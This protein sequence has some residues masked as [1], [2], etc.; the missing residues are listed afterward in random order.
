MLPISLSVGKSILWMLRRLGRTGSALPG[1]VVEKLYKPFLPRTLAQ[2]P[3]GVIVVTG[4]NGK[5]TTAKLIVELFEAQGL[6]VLTNK[7]G[8]NF[9]RGIITTVVDKATL[10]GKLDYDIAVLEQ[11]EA[12]AV[13]FVAQVKPVGVVALNVMRD[14]MDRFG[15]IDTTTRL[16][17]KVVKSASDWLVLNASDRRIS[18][19]AT[20]TRQ[21]IIWFGYDQQLAKDFVSDDQLYHHDQ[22]NYFAAALPDVCLM[23]HRSDSLSVKL[24]TGVETFPVKLGG[25]HNAL[26]ITA[27]LAAL[28]AIC[29][30]ADLLKTSR[31]LANFQPAFGRGEKIILDNGQQ[32]D[33]QL[34]KNPSGFSYALQLLKENSYLA[35]GLAINDAAADGHDVSWLWDV[36]FEVLKDYKAEIVC[37]GTRGLDMALR[38]K[39]D[40]VSSGQNHLPLE[41]FLRELLD[42]S[43]TGPAIIFCTYSAMLKLRIMLA[44]HSSTLEKVVV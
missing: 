2:L 12:H 26:N 44:R 27:A 37:G 8:S 30:A 29:P 5:T 21:R 35:V 3:K 15:E 28:E 36:N 7:S 16:I 41:D 31:V 24:R 19:L 34:I 33:I 14:Q 1:L 6:R 17:G 23:S 32:L 20:D 22:T 25:G 42:T 39:Y 43:K 18:N 40:E 9:V 13:H 38:L 4:T 10:G 11:D